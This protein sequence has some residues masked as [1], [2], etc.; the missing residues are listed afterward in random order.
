MSLSAVDLEQALN[1]NEQH[2][3]LRERTGAD[4]L[5]E[6]I[7]VKPTVKLLGMGIN[8]LFRLN[9]QA[10]PVCFANLLASAV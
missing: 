4:I 3:F 9:I 6:Q 10:T 1:K 8:G 2:S 7:Y 5:N